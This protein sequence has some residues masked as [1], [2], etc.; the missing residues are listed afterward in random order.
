MLVSRQH[1]GPA[2]ATRPRARCLRAGGRDA[3]G[4]RAGPL[5]RLT[6]PLAGAV[7][8]GPTDL[9]IAAK[10]NAETDVTNVA[11]YAGTQLSAPHPRLHTVPCGKTQPSAV[12]G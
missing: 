6:T 1:L 10:A 11:F 2:P 5:V 3:A 12:I 9:T 8:E 4:D 7:I